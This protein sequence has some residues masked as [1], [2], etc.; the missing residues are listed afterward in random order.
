[1]RA[2]EIFQLELI[3]LVATTFAGIALAGGLV[4]IVFCLVRNRIDA[5]EQR[6]RSWLADGLRRVLETEIIPPSVVDAVGRNRQLAADLLDEMS[7]LVRSAGHGRVLHLARAAGLD[8][9]LLGRLRSGNIEQRLAAA[10]T[11]SLFDQ[12]ETIAAL[13]DAL[14]NREDEVRLAAALSLVDLGAAPPMTAL[15][16]LLVE[17][18]HQRSLILRVLFER[19]ARRHW[20]EVFEV[21][22]GRIGE[23]FLR[24]IAIRAIGVCG[25]GHL[26][27]EITDF[28]HDL[29]PEVRAAA[30]EALGALGFAPGRDVIEVALRDAV[31]FVR[32][33][34]INAARRL[35][36]TDL[37]PLV[38]KL[39]DD[40]NWW[41]QFRAG[42]ALAALK[43]PG[44]RPR[45]I[46]SARA[47]APAQR[48]VRRQ[49][50]RGAA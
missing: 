50:Q 46:A 30:I 40:P 19:L 45:D 38:A 29:D 10:S 26:G 22:A 9:W 43:G 33:R 6:Q 49:S 21:A 31:P 12:P 16:R 23:P 39:S 47:K 14:H 34:A 2:N 24:P 48:K 36:L 37:A 32:V 8:R 25:H 35:Q 18:R 5:R 11:L 28:A 42:E 44:G 20:A 13:H 3:I 17:E 4:T 7:D 41:V 15:V 1:L 27:E